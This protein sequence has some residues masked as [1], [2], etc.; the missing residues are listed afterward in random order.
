MYAYSAYTESVRFQYDPAKAVSNLRKH[1]VSFADAEGVFYDPLAI[2]R[3][4][5][6]SIDEERF[7][8][9]GMGSAGEILV[10]IYTLRDEEIRIISARH[11]T[12]HEVKSY[13]N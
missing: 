2:H 7:V 4:E 1:G 5:P 3:L 13:E 9:V 11:A 6:D 12:R 10:V 8:A